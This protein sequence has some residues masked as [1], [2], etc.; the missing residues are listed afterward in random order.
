LLLILYNTLVSV[1]K[2]YAKDR[3]YDDLLPFE[4]TT[5]IINN[6]SGKFEDLVL[7]IAKRETYRHRDRDNTDML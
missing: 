5:G 7:M 1:T 2:L 4:C 3:N 6:N